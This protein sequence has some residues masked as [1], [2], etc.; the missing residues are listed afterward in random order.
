VAGGKRYLCAGEYHRDPEGEGIKDRKT[1][2][3]RRIMLVPKRGKNRKKKRDGV[4]GGGD[5]GK[6]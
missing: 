4:D 1:S 2:P 5:K 3:G 6:R